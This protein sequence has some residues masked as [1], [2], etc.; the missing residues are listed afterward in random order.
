MELTDAFSLI[1]IEKTLHAEFK[2]P[3]ITD[4]RMGL[5]CTGTEQ[6]DYIIRVG[7]KYHSTVTERLLAKAAQCLSL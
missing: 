2:A 4:M 3:D 1:K 5:T 6:D 7:V